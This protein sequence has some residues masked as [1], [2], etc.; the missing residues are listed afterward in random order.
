M[1][2]YK[3]KMCE[4]VYDPQKGHPGAGIKSDTDFNDLPEEWRC[5]V[6]GAP[7]HAFDETDK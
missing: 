2:K 3:C 1:K 5:P 4:Y 6:C 7:K